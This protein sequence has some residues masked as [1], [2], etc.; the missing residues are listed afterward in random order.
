MSGEPLITVHKQEEFS[1]VGIGASAGGQYSARAITESG[2]VSKNV[3]KPS[4]SS[5]ALSQG[6]HATDQCVVLLP[7]TKMKRGFMS[8]FMQVL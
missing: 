3:S 1:I 8:G 4:F 6:A 7:W 2:I 5:S